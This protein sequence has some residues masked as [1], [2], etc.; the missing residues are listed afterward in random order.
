LVK[1]A[2]RASL[3]IFGDPAAVFSLIL[4]PGSLALGERER[5]CACRTET[6]GR[7]SL[8]QYRTGE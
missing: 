6:G 2:V 5:S 7:L 8:S 3:A 1:P 4:V